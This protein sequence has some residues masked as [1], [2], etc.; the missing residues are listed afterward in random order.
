MS[1]PIAR[2]NGLVFLSSSK[3]QPVNELSLF[4]FPPLLRLC[5]D[6]LKQYHIGCCKPEKLLVVGRKVQVHIK[7]FPALDAIGA[8]QYERGVDLSLGSYLRYRL[9]ICDDCEVVWV[10]SGRVSC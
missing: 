5:V 3:V 9:P 10:K 8:E 6:R 2:R 1:K 4:D 7:Y